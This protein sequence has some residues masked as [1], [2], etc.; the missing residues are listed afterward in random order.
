MK[1]E[2][3]E[4]LKHLN[5]SLFHLSHLLTLTSGF[6]LLFLNYKSPFKTRR[7]DLRS[8]ISMFPSSEPLS[9]SGGPPKTPAAP[10]H[11]QLSAQTGSS[12]SWSHLDPGPGR[13]AREPDLSAGLGLRLQDQDFGD[14]VGLSDSEMG[15]GCDSGAERVLV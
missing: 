3:S 12:S 14:L 8:F 9:Q 1:F 7:S 11:C 6:F 13:S 5:L 2:A 4:Q 10:R 15:F